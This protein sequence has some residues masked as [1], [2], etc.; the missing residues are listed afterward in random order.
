MR[1][2]DR[3]PE[4]RFDRILLDAP[5]SGL[6]VIRRKPDLKWFKRAEDIAG[7]SALQR[8]LLDTLGGLLRPGGKIVYST[9][10]LEPSENERVIEHFLANWDDF[11]IDPGLTDHLTPEVRKK[12][13]ISAGMIRVLPSDFG[14]DGFFIAR[15]RRTC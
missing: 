14:S 5:C 10:T 12:C 7:I 2:K 3:F 13:V 8:E 6:G 11:E 4:R 1:L 9:C 15:M